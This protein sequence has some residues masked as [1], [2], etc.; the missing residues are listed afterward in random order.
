[1]HRGEE[2][3]VV[4]HAGLHHRFCAACAFLR[5]LEDQFDGAAKQGLQAFEHV[6]QPQA[7]G[8]MAV[9]TA[10][11]HH[12]AVARGEAFTERQVFGF[13]QFVEIEGVHI[14]AVGDS[15]AGAAGIERCDDAGEAA[16]KMRQPF[17][18]RA[19]IAGA[20]FLRLQLIGRG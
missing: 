19:L 11:M 2:I 17:F 20:Q 8:G 4:H 18:Q 10:C 7:D 14:H 9:M 15:R 6:R 16:G 13:Q 1:M 3:D 5:R 12:A